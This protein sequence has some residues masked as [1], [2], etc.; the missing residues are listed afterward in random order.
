MDIAKTKKDLQKNHSMS[1]SLFTPYVNAIENLTVKLISSDGNDIS[2]SEI[3]L[4]LDGQ[5][6]Q[7]LRDVVPITDLK[8]TGAFFTNHHLS[9]RL[10]KSIIPDIKQGQA[11]S[12]PACGTGNLFLACARHLPILENI[13]ETLNLWGKQLYG[14]DLHPEFIRAA[15][16]RL[17]LLAIERGARGSLSDIN[18][19]D[20]FPNIQTSNY[21]SF[22]SE[23][24]KEGCIVINP[25]YTMV[26]VRFSD[27]FVI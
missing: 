3:Q 14:S 9:N 21:L 25:P 12:D 16:T 10:I 4:V 17:I 18:F 24:L 11:I 8:R 22:S 27:F 26:E 13:R 2:N 23:L 6:M 19:S 15:K 1:M 5:P 20:F 7:V